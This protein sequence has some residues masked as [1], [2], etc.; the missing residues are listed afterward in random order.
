MSCED[1]LKRPRKRKRTAKESDDDATSNEDGLKRPRKRRRTT[2]ESDDDDTSNDESGDDDTSNEDGL[3]ASSDSSSLPSSSSSSSSS[4]SDG[5]SKK[6]R[7]TSEIINYMQE[8]KEKFVTSTLKQREFREAQGAKMEQMHNDSVTAVVGDIVA[9]NV[10]PRDRTD[11][12]PRSLVGIVFARG[13]ATVQVATENG[14]LKAG[15]EKSALKLA[16]DRYAVRSYLAPIP[17][18]LEVIRKKV[19][20]G[21][22]QPN[23]ERH[24][25]MAGAHM[26]MVGIPSRGKCMCKK[27]C[28]GNCGCK[29]KGIGCNYNCR[30][31][32]KCGNPNNSSNNSVL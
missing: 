19:Q 5:G 13:D 23:N 26:E 29:K 28:K 15:K 2:F 14:I 12:N 30:C 16:Q 24:L 27:G 6:C 32:G 3:R 10:D 22:F 8:R 20:D 21:C 31:K 18:K 9:V 4:S 17:P 7:Q 1:G 25:S 11:I